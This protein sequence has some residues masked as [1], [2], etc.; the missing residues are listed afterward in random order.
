MDY[1][2]GELENQVL[3]SLIPMKKADGLWENHFMS[4]YNGI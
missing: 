4:K 2:K 1:V 3:N